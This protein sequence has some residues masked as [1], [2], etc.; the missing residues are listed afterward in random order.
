M[1]PMFYGP[2]GEPIGP[3]EWRRCREDP[4]I[5]RVGST[6]LSGVW[7][8]TVWLGTDQGLG[9]GG[10][11]PLIYET[12]VFKA[13]TTESVMDREVYATRTQALAGHDQVVAE[14]RAIMASTEPLPEWDS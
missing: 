3:E 1:R 8:S 14:V 2:D 4:A 6:E 9:L 7:V 12:M 5:H 11:L 13:G 10:T